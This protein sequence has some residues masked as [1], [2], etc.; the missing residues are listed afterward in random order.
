VRWF[1]RARDV[2]EP[3]A[4]LGH[5]SL[6][7]RALVDGLHPASRPAVLDLGPP[8]AGN[9][10]FL[11]ALSCRVRVVD[12]HRSLCAEPAPSLRPGA[13]AA[14]FER[15]LPLELDERFD[16]LLAWDVF[17]YMRG[18]QVTALMARLLPRL[19][20]A[21]QLMVLVS[22]LPRIPAIPARYR[23]L[24]RE[25]LDCERP[26]RDG[27]HLEPMRPSPRYRQSDLARMMPGIVVRRCYLL[28]SGIQEYLLARA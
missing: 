16:A 2:S 26:A 27:G 1:A 3:A 7:L 9:V 4:A 22:T 21:A 23:I 6:A 5:R 20:P 19:Q 18:D 24:D 11:S 15:L 28:R 12:L 14:V 25:T 10:K 13:V 8:L 17:D